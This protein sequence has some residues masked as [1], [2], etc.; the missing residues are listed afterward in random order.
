MVSKECCPVCSELLSA[1]GHNNICG[2][3]PTIFAVELPPW[4]P[5]TVL[6]DMI[7]RFELFLATEIKNM[8]LLKVGH[9]RSPSGQSQAGL[10]TGSHE[11]DV[12]VDNTD[13]YG[14]EPTFEHQFSVASEVNQAATI[15][16][17]VSE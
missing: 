12:N 2:S 9:R 15:Y 3:H 7:A 16:R 11:N 17:A 1:L 13:L 14:D 10:S 5:A 8:M 4:L 6:K